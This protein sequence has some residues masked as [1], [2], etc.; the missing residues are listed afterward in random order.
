MSILIIS[1]SRNRN[2][3]T[4][5]ALGAIT[6][7]IAA[8]GGTSEMIFLPELSIECCRQCDSEGWGKC[9]SEHQ[10]IIQDDFDAV[11]KKILA[12]DAAVFASPVYFMDLSESLRSLLERYRR[13]NFLPPGSPARP[14][15][16]SAVGLCY[17][18]GSGN[19]TTNCAAN[20]EKILQMCG[21]DV[22]DMINVRRQNLEVKMPMLEMAGKWLVS[23]PTSGGPWKPTA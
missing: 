1:G 14:K 10:C 17:A 22:V 6:K 2:G 4:A 12:S 7:G 15:P 3:K 11:M 19:G 18:G 8:A 21:F 5:Q 20:M 23:K 9:R 13:V 16:V